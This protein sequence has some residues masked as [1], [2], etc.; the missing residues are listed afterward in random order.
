MYII[1]MITYCVELWFAARYY[2]PGERASEQQTARIGA[3]PGETAKLQGCAHTFNKCDW[4]W[5]REVDNSMH[6]RW[7]SSGL[8][9][10]LSWPCVHIHDTWTPVWSNTINGKQDQYQTRGNNSHQLWQMRCD[11]LDCVR[12]AEVSIS[13][14]PRYMNV[15]CIALATETSSQATGFPTRLSCADKIERYR[16]LQATYKCLLGG[17]NSKRPE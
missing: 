7:G 8:M 12:Q 15:T 5:R 10:M 1:R 6:I 13:R 9:A 16:A 2:L 14:Y 3:G 4:D 11:Q 17:V